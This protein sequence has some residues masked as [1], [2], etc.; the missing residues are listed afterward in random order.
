MGKIWALFTDKTATEVVLNKISSDNTE[1]LSVTS[2]SIHDPKTKSSAEKALRASFAAMLASKQ[3]DHKINYS[4]S[5]EFKGL[6]PYIDSSASLAFALGLVVKIHAI[7]FS[8]AATGVIEESSQSAT[9]ERVDKIDNKILAAIDVLQSGDMVFYPQKNHKEIPQDTIE[10]AQKNN[11]IL[12]P[13][14]TII[15]AVKKLLKNKKVKVQSK[16]I[17]SGSGKAKR[18]ILLFLGFGIFLILC[19]PLILYLSPHHEN[20][21]KEILPIAPPKKIHPIEKI[22]IIKPKKIRIKF[23]LT[24]NDKNV[25]ER[26]Q[27]KLSYLFQNNGFIINQAN[28]DGII[29]GRV[30]LTEIQRVQLRPYA[31]P[32]A[33]LVRYQLSLKNLTFTSTSGDKVFIDTKQHTFQIKKNQRDILQDIVLEEII[34]AETVLRIIKQ[35]Y[36]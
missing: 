36:E 13:V 15:D 7:P 3:L 11:I 27:N 26:F 22:Q 2:V 1:K 14:D 23:S 4:F 19:S 24:G 9:V 29:S 10:I 31:P 28:Y 33:V 8:I 35:L 18:N 6:A 25:T 12:I 5:Y 21:K 20:R 34:K 16:K 30:I 17:T 32:D